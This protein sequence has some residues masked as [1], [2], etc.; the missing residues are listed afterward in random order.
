[1][2]RLFANHRTAAPNAIAQSANLDAEFMAPF[3]HRV[4]FSVGFVLSR[5]FVMCAAP[6]ARLSDWCIQR[7]GDR[8]FKRVD[9][10]PDHGMRHAEFVCPI[11]DALRP[12]IVRQHNGRALVARLRARQSPSAIIWRVI[13][14]VV[15]AIKRVFWRRT[16]SHVGEE[17]GKVTP[18]FAYGYSTTSIVH[19]GRVVLPSA[20]VVHLIPR[21]EFWRIGQSVFSCRATHARLLSAFLFCVSHLRSLANL[22]RSTVAPTKPKLQMSVS[23]RRF[24]LFDNRPFAESLTF[25]INRLA[26]EVAPVEY[27]NLALC[28]R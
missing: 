17:I 13:S 7:F 20:S 23:R 19:K 28:G 3:L 15:D 2:S 12:S 24:R 8:P 14:I 11:H 9:S 27:P 5:V 25:Q 18:S 6:V 10:L 1:M 22:L 16:F 4:L 26:H 21:I